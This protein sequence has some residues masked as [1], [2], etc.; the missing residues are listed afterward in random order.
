M[1]FDL[2]ASFVFSISQNMYFDMKEMDTYNKGL[3]KIHGL[4]LLL[5]V[6]VQKSHSF[7]NILKSIFI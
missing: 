5:N 7:R 3:I 6:S 4:F 1:K 2:W